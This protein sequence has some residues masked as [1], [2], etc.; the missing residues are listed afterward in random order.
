MPNEHWTNAV[1]G[2]EPI[3]TRRPCQMPTRRAGGRHSEPWGPIVGAF[4]GWG[5]SHPAARC[6]GWHMA[7]WS[8]ARPRLPI[9]QFRHPVEPRI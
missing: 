1:P 8:W 2:I 6:P 9:S 4:D 5:R 3:W 7:G